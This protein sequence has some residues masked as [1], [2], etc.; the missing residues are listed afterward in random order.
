M[1]VVG[2]CWRAIGDAFGVIGTLDVMLVCDS[3]VPV[4]DEQ[5]LLWADYIIC[6]I[7]SLAIES[8]HKPAS[9]SV[10]SSRLQY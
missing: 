4:S 6:Y 1:D 3:V 2:T 8:T 7:R 10:D 9:R 5:F